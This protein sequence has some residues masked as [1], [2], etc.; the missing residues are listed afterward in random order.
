MPE[1]SRSALGRAWLFCLW[2]TLP[3]VVLAVILI[4]REHISLPSA[5]LILGCLVVYLAL[6]SAALI[7]SFI[8]PMQT[9]SNVIA[10]LREGDY[11]FRARGAGGHDP[12][13]ELSGE[14]NALA[15]ILQRQRVSSLEA[16]ALLAQWTPVYAYGFT[17]PDARF[18]LP[19]RRKLNAFHGAELQF[20]FDAPMNWFKRH[21][22]GDER[23][24]SDAMMDYWTSFARTGHPQAVHAPDWAAYGAS[25]AYMHFADD[26]PHAAAHLMPGMFDLHEE[27]VCR[28]RASAQPWN[29][30]TGIV[31]PPLGAHRACS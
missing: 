27:A 15:D 18:I 30:N 17:Y 29:W 23:R 9:L 20:V 3:A 19:E 1:S 26:G 24:L 13:G 25:G 14:V 4:V 22:T 16:T 10:S 8:R 11:S 7:E 21:F 5:L 31:S 28:R 2:L 12:L 6:I